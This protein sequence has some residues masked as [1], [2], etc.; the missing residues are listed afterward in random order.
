MPRSISLARASPTEIAEGE[1]TVQLR[2]G[3]SAAAGNGDSKTQAVS[4]MVKNGLLMF[5][6]PSI[7]TGLIE[8]GNPISI[9]GSSHQLA[10]AKIVPR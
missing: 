10:L 7:Q 9:E 8:H 4:K 3:R 2:T 5:S 1:V 6:L